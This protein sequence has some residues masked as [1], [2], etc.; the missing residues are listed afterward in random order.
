MAKKFGTGKIDESQ[1]SRKWAEGVK[2]QISGATHHQSLNVRYLPLKQL[3]LDPDNPRRLSVSLNQVR[4]LRELYPLEPSWI[5][6]DIATE[7][8]D[9]YIDQVGQS[10]SGKS[11]TDY[12]GLVNLAVAIKSHERLINPVTV[13]SEESGTDL[14]LIAGERRYL[15]HVLLGE[16]LIAARI[17]AGRPDTLEKDILQWEEN[18]QRVDLTFSE[19]VHNL[20]RLVD[21]WEKLRGKRL[22]V[23]QLVSLAGLPRV[24]AHRYLTVIR[25][26]NPQ[27]MELI[28]AGKIGSLRKAADLAALSFSQLQAWLTPEKPPSGPA[29]IFVIKRS[30][31]YDPIKKILRIACQQLGGKTYLKMID[32]QVLDTPEAI[33]AAFDQLVVHVSKGMTNGS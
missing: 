4:D 33:A 24:T 16:E 5:A 29:P 1:G 14:K 26:E 30:K 7:W 9:D 2:S 31:N 6:G 10:V 32:N 25:Y 18:N 27:L 28:E 20:K 13:Y 19:Q 8:W 22:S 23:S 11:L 3:T 21:G 12:M 17:L 15:A